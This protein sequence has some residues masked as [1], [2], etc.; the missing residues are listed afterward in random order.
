MTMYT[1]FTFTFSILPVVLASLFSVFLGTPVHAQTF[2]PVPATFP[3]HTFIE[4]QGFYIFG[5]L[6]PYTSTA[7]T[8]AFMIDLSVSWNA[9]EPVL[10]NLV[11]GPGAYMT[12]CTP[13]SNGE[14][15]LLLHMGH[16]YIYNIK[17][18]SWSP[19]FNNELPIHIIHGVTDPESGIM[20]LIGVD[21]LEAD[22]PNGIEQ[23]FKYHFHALDLRT[24]TFHRI[25]TPAHNNSIGKPAW[26]ASL[27]SIL[28][29]TD[30]ITLLYVFT[31]SRMNESSHGWSL[32]YTTG[33][34]RLQVDGLEDCFVPA[35]GGSKMVYFKYLFDGPDQNDQTTIL[36][37]DVATRTWTKGTPAG[38]LQR[39]VCA[40]SGDHLVVW[41]S[42]RH[43][44][45]SSTLVY[46]MASNE[47][48][49][50]YTPRSR[51]R[52]RD[53]EEEHVKIIII[54]TG[55]LL[56]V[57]LTTISFYLGLTKQVKDGVQSTSSSGSSSN[58]LGT[59]SDIDITNKLST[60]VLP[61]DPTCPDSFSTG[62]PSSS[63]WK[64]MM[65]IS[66]LFRLTV[67]RPPPKHPHVIVGDLTAKRGVQEGAIEI[68]SISQDP[69]TVIEQEP[70]ATFSDKAESESSDED[71]CIA[72]CNKSSVNS[73]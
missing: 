27:K 59:E 39:H 10:K 62:A 8:Q 60:V 56:T 50:S 54:V 67:S 13:T 72:T 73:R 29:A 18:G 49:S 48:V 4:G 41:N 32:M 63:R 28:F 25:E 68:E 14:D 61:R 30:I 2:R 17:S 9:S 22:P 40:V 21:I 51:V 33:G 43:T 24:M 20:Y 1:T 6:D 47:W 23:D 37:L 34:E 44:N 31:P 64:E 12:A 15:I 70:I 45:T 38:D 16:G 55:V 53:T 35:Y 3:G 57:I 65:S 5:G 58:S 52:V 46:N 7:V 71:E 26:S 42:D 69:H 11:N 66:N 19:V 36:I